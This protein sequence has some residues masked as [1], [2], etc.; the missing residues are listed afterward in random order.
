[1]DTLNI[2]YRDPTK[3]QALVVQGKPYTAQLTWR[4]K[5]EVVLHETVTKLLSRSLG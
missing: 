5:A 1:M 4:S 2:E 3:N